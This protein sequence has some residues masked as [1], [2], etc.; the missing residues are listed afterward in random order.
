MTV[1]PGISW[2]VA[3]SVPFFLGGGLESFGQVR[4][5]FIFLQL[6][7]YSMR[8]DSIPWHTLLGMTWGYGG[9]WGGRWGGGY[10]GSTRGR[11]PFGAAGREKG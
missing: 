11:S 5:R 3:Q 4:C 8:P 7:S 1:L 2:K 6:K 10:G 9:Y